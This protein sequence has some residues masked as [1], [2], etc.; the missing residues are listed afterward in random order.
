[1][2]LPLFLYYIPHSDY[3]WFFL[4]LVFLLLF[5]KKKLHGRSKKSPYA[6]IFVVMF[7]LAFDS[8]MTS[9]STKHTILEFYVAIVLFNFSMAMM[10]LLF[11][12]KY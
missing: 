1:M 6:L 4:N 5:W 7:L 12:R 8:F 10:A 9:I 2:K 3:V 11:N